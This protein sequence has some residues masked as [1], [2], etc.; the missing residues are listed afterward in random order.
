M[1]GQLSGFRLGDWTT[2]PEFGKPG[3]GHESRLEGR[4]EKV[5]G[6][7]GEE[8]VTIAAVLKQWIGRVLSCQLLLV[9]VPEIEIIQR[10][11]STGELILREELTESIGQCGLPA[12]LR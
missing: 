3:E 10:E 7:R 9:L 12:A 4:R 11:H 2:G 1:G 6:E 8:R 5:R